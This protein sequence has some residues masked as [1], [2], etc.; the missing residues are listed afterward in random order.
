[1][2][3]PCSLTGE[4]IEMG[5]HLTLLPLTAA[6]RR[7]QT[8]VSGK[9]T[10]IQKRFLA[11]SKPQLWLDF[12]SILAV[13]KIL[14][15]RVLKGIV[16]LGLRS[17]FCWVWREWEEALRSANE[18]AMGH[19]VARA[20]VTMETAIAGAWPEWSNNGRGRMQY[21]CIGGLGA[22]GLG[23]GG[24]WGFGLGTFI[25]WEKGIDEVTAV[26]LA[27]YHWTRMMHWRS[28]PTS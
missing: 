16:S 9:L 20:K 26:S 12:S 4:Q 11:K 3:Q 8:S 18:E 7:K 21:H 15:Q 25:C 23:L 2:H 5:C 17:I 6:A 14:G 28:M 1:M 10:K 13:S 19:A 24:L 22:L 27:Q